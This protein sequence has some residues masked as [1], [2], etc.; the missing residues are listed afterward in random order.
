MVKKLLILL[1]KQKLINKTV[2]DRNHTEEIYTKLKELSR[3]HYHLDERLT[4]HKNRYKELLHLCFPEFEL[5]FKDERI[6][7]LTALNFIKEFPYAY[8]IK[9]RRVDALVYN[10]A[11]TN[12]RHLNYFK[13]KSRKVNITLFV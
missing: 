11:N 9:N 1:E 10:M 2:H 6:Y 3:H 8:I 12:N 4:R 5:C 7:D 13:R